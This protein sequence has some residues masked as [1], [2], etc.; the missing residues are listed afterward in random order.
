LSKIKNQYQQK[1]QI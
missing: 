1:E